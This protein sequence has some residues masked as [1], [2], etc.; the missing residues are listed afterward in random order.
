MTKG[1][2]SATSSLRTLKASDVRASRHGP[3]PVRRIAS[4]QRGLRS[5]QAL[6][7][8][9]AENA[10]LSGAATAGSIRHSS[11]LLQLRTALGTALSRGLSQLVAWRIRQRGDRDRAFHRGRLVV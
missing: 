4:H 3:H 6:A 1:R 5:A 11:A 2:L 10:L 8:D 9:M 7:S